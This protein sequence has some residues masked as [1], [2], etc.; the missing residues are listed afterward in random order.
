[1]AQGFLS[2]GGAGLLFVLH[3]P[4]YSARGSLLEREKEAP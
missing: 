3:C 1:M 4:F 2:Y